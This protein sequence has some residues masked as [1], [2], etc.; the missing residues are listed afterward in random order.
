MKKHKLNIIIPVII[1]L[2]I[3]ITTLW[4]FGPESLKQIYRNLQPF[5]LVLSIFMTTITF[6][7]NTL[8]MEVILKAHNKKAPF[9]NVLRQ[10]IAG[11][12]VSYVTP[13]ARIGG[14]PLRAYML[15][16][17]CNIDLKTSTSAVIIDKFIEFFGTL[18]IGLIGL[19]ILFF[20]PSPYELK[21]FLGTIMIISFII[22]FSIYYMTI[23]GKGPFT[24]LFN[25]L[26]FYRI[27][28][29]KK[30]KGIIKDIEQKMNKIFKNNHK[31]FF[32]SYI[33]YFL[34]ALTTLYEFKFVLLAIGIKSNFIEL[35][36]IMVVWGLINLIPV[37]GGIGFQEAGQ[38]SLFALIKNSGGIGFAFTLLTRIGIMIFISIGFGIIS[39]FSGTEIIKR[40]KSNKE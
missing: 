4:Y 3:F 22:L 1:G 34:S 28:K 26:Q 13:S 32:L 38:S 12:A 19:L 35:V 21:L 30:F 9:L 6:L 20:I 36:L 10:N 29:Y 7:I 37:P 14:E 5:Y 23:I 11:Y 17:E 31:E 15:K 40:I 33:L 24:T 39:N 25:I 2:L 18:T 16:K 8:R 27:P